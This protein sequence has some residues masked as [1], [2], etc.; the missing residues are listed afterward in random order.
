MYFILEI[1]IP[2]PLR[3]TF[4]YLGSDDTVHWKLGNRVIVPFGSREVTGIICDIKKTETLPNKLKPV[5][6]YL[7]E[8][9]FLPK[10]L[11][12][13]ICWVSKY[14]HHP[15]GECFQAALPKRLRQNH[16]AILNFETIWIKTTED[17]NIKSQ[18]QKQILE[19]IAE[20]Q[21]GISQKQL[22]QQFG[23]INK[24]LLSME[25]IGL[26]KQKQQPEV[27]FNNSGHSQQTPLN[28]EQKNAFDVIQRHLENFQPFLLQG[29]TGSG[30]TEL[31]L[32]LCQAQIAR[33][34]QVL[35]L[36]PEI[37]LTGQFVS[38]F[39]QGLNAKLALTHSAVSD[40]QRQQ[41]WLLS[42]E[43]HVDVIIGTRSAIFT[44]LQNP[45]LIII[46]E[47]HDAS[48]KQQD[49]LRYHARN[50][51]L[52]R[53]RNLSIPIVLG[54]ATPSLE[55]LYQVSQ[56]RYTLLELTKRAGNACLPY[57]E[58]VSC[59]TLKAA[60]QG[61]SPTLIAE[62]RVH[63][64]QQQQVLVFIN[65]RGFAPVLMCHHCDW[66]ATCRSCDAK[67]VVHQQRNVLF[68]HHCGF[69]QKLPTACPECDTSPL[70]SYGVGTEKIEQALMMLFPEVPVIRMDRDTTQR[71]NAFAE[72]VETI[73]QG[74]P[75]ILVGTQMLAKGH[76]F[77]GVTLVGVIDAD[78]GL[79][80]A[81]FR[82]TE[83]LAQLITQV[84]GRA[85]R[86]DKAGK[87][88]IQTQQIHHPFWPPLLHQGY[89]VVAA[90]ILEERIQ[91]GLPPKGFWAVWRAEA[92]QQ[93]LAMALLTEFVE[94]IPHMSHIQI[95][96]PVPALMEKRAGRYRAQ[97][98]LSSAHRNALHQFIAQGLPVM[99]KCKLARK[100]RWSIDI[101]PTELL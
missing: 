36:I 87:V 47:E 51:A 77:H 62:M 68:C 37:G 100:V 31:Y 12:K 24:S 83:L 85:G 80:S 23:Q 18:K 11:F 98:L 91:L 78:Q 42:R 26:I 69:I 84:T 61:L 52:L 22:K 20:H 3:Q 1:A 58:L 32:H 8:T 76:D 39:Q 96:G 101:D 82:A 97:L 16:P 49:G 25:S 66:Q 48:F 27:F 35:I 44:P 21:K 34:K 5:T 60:D 28:A 13:L 65:R 2:C 54:S 6:R 15:I 14:Y 38:R 89:G 92:F 4:D 99:Q 86:G 33:G 10:E 70:T 88:I 81:D 53:A 17:I 50:I 59:E 19:Y 72:M 93:D 43:G 41:T 63:L 67:M 40:K 46:D 74:Q 55:S 90:H 30:K 45:G 71:K 79:F 94:K 9:A 7:D 64:A 57:V 29:I 95:M 75:A 56:Q 73:Q